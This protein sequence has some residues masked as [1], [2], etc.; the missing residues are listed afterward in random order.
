MTVKTFQ[1]CLSDDLDNVFINP[2]EFAIAFT[3]DSPKNSVVAKA[4][5]GIFTEAFEVDS[6]DTDMQVQSIAPVMRIKTADIPGGKVRPEDFVTINSIVYLVTD[7]Q[8]D[9]T[10]VT[11]LILKVK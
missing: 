1:D 9:G 11:D 6:P 3:Y 4:V 5:D 10:G 7:D 8:A 2:K